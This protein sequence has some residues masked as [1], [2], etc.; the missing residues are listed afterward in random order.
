MCFTCA[1]SFIRIAMSQ[2]HTFV[3]VTDN[4]CDGSIEEGL[5]SS[6]AHGLTDVLILR[7]VCVD[8]KFVIYAE[9]HEYLL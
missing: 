9:C 6:L 4:R 8:L 7:T 1:T 3:W 2:E 5:M